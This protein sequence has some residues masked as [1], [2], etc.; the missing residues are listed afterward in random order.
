MQK[1]TFYQ[2]LLLK[3]IKFSMRTKLIYY[4][5]YG[6]SKAKYITIVYFF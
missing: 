4:F 3:I 5:N 6:A 1:Y 2:C